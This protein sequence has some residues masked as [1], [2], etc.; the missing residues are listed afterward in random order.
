L[1]TS[2]SGHAS[3][4]SWQALVNTALARDAKTATQ[5]LCAHIDDSAAQIVRQLRDYL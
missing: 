3:R 1:R 2:G 5:V 4:R